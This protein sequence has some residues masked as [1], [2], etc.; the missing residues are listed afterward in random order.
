MLIW[1]D[2]ET[3]G[4]NP[5][6]DAILEAAVIITDDEFKEVARNS[7][8][9]SAA[10]F[11]DYKSMDPFVRDMH[12]SNGLWMESLRAPEGCGAQ[13]LDGVMREFIDEHAPPVAGEGKMSGD[14]P[15]LAGNS[16]WF[17]RTFVHKYLDMFEARL[18]YRMLDVTSV[19]LLSVRTWPGVFAGRPAPDGGN[20]RAMPD[21][22]NSIAQAQWYRSQLT[23]CCSSSVCGAV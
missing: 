12:H 11:R 10:Q 8:V 20:H 23:P 13:W 9:T 1:L 21:V 19:N 18:H 4:L 15:H 16:I 17:D 5:N 6:R 2:L 7:W 14:K 22:E 3:T